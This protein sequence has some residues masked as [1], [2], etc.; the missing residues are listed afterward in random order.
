[1]AKQDVFIR[2]SSGL[3][4]Q[5]SARDALMYSAMNPGLLYALVYI[6]WAPAFYPGTNMA[7]AVMFVL[8]IFP[9]AGL[10]WY[11]SVSMPRSGG[12]YIYVSRTLH[13][14]LGLFSCFVLSITA[15]SWTGQLQ[16]WWVRWGL[17]DPIRAVGISSGNEGWI[18]VAN[19]IDKPIVRL[20]IGTVALVA[21]G[22]LFL[23]GTKAM[24]RLSYWA[25]GFAWLAVL[26]LGFLLV[27]T[28]QDG[29]RERFNE[30]SG[31]EYDQILAAGREAGA[32]FGI[33]FLAVLY[34]GMV[35][36][37]LNTLGQTFSANLAGEVRGVAKS[38]AVALFGSLTMQMAIWFAIYL[39]VYGIVGT[40]F[41][42]S[43]DSIWVDDSSQLPSALVH[44]NTSSEPVPMILIAFMTGNPIL[45]LL[46][47]LC[48]IIATWISLAGLGF[49][50]VRNAFAWS[51]D[52]LI[53]TKFSEITTKYRAPLWSIVAACVLAWVFLYLGIYSAAYSSAILYSIVAW[54]IGWIV[55]GIAGMVYPYRRKELFEAGPP[56]TQR[57]FAGI[58]VIS[59]LGFLTL[60]VSL[61]TEWAV[62][63]P[64][65]KG[66]AEPEQYIT[67]AAM[68][69]TPI[70]IYLIAHF[71]H[72]SRGIPLKEQFSQ[73]PPE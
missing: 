58:P 1:M 27:V 28:G 32:I 38:Q 59:I 40:N 72:K 14:A 63:Q 20:L 41:M 12:E 26:I 71:Y 31:A 57:R 13:P 35:Y 10:Y 70:V 68:C 9:I 22:W 19:T 37:N 21:T 55:L 61:G 11:F 56:A 69:I 29:F 16:D 4:R 60:A 15:L 67:V 24:M 45:Q 36:V 8:L 50:T 30:L 23:K 17:A 52:R 65:I 64:F 51:F 2:Q 43:L 6:V 7:L 5:I 49:A 3:T 53:P 39:L 34:A 66:D 44:E 42:H 25:V 18:D 73:V 33:E 47:G 46:F 48:F 54:F 62:A